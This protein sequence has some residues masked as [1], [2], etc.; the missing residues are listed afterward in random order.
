M[1]FFYS[2]KEPI[3]IL[4]PGEQY[5]ITVSPSERSQKT[6]NEDFYNFLFS[7]EF[8]SSALFEKTDSFE[9][10]KKLAAP[11]PVKDEKTNGGTV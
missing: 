11:K 6:N 3:D 1:Y 10:P 7:N 9:P 4:V 5:A 2:G 8:E